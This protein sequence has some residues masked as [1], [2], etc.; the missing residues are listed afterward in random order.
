MQATPPTFT[1]AQIARA[2]GL[3]KR[4]VFQVLGSVTSVEIPSQGG[5]AHAWSVAALPAPFQEH[6][7][8]EAERCGF[9]SAEHLL[10]DPSKPWPPP[11]LRLSEISPEAWEKARKLKA[12]LLAS[13]RRRDDLGLTAAEFD[14]QGVR[15]YQ[16]AFGY[17]IHPRHFRRLLERTLKRDAGAEDFE[18]LDLYLPENP[19][20]K[21]DRAPANALLPGSVIRQLDAMITAFAAASGPT[22]EQRNFVWETVFELFEESGEGGQ[23]SASVKAAFETYLVRNASFLGPN[24]NAIRVNWSRKYQQWEK[25]GRQPASLDDRRRQGRTRKRQLTEDEVE[26]LRVFCAKRDNINLGWRDFL[27]SAHALPETKA[28]H[29]PSGECR[30]QVPRWIRKLVKC[31]TTNLQPYLRGPR[32]AKLQG[33]YIER[34]PNSQAA[35]DTDQ[36]DDKTLE[37]YW[38][39]DTPDGRWFGQGQLLVWIDER[40]WFIYSFALISDKSYSGFSIRNSWTKKAETWGL[41]RE[42]IYVEMG[43]WREAKVFAGSGDQVGLSETEMGVRR[44]GLKIK[45]ALLPRGK[46]I[47]RVFG[48][49]S[50]LLQGLPGYAGRNQ[51]VDKWETVQKQLALCRSGKEDPAQFFLSKQQMLDVLTETADKINN[52]AKWGKYHGG[53]TPTQVFEEKF[54]T[55]LVK[56]PDGCRHLFASNKIATTVG[57]NGVRFEF[58]RHTFTYKNSIELGRLKGERVICWFHPENPDFISVTDLNGENPIVVPREPLVPSHEAGEAF[59]RANEASANF[60]RYHKEMYRTLRP[61]FDAAFTARLFRPVVADAQTLE[62]HTNIHRQQQAAEQAQQQVRRDRTLAQRNLRDVGLYHD[63]QKPLRPGQADA[64]K[65]LKR[66]LAEP[67][68]GGE[69]LQTNGDRYE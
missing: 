16:R 10:A 43:I 30:P 31:S 15:D 11:D 2:L 8:A 33:A 46:I 49:L 34:D 18:R 32:A 45:H 6:L 41:P 22:N 53:K 37:I 20:R 26:W 39:E 54:T 58:G 62:V 50:D 42:R 23:I 25:A 56:I 29:S 36:S 12:A 19:A 1:A 40:S 4:R 27:E 52:T 5:P 66:L 35:G 63:P 14:A 68:D 57:R 64:A 13:L 21:P 3:S 17:G 67:V 59:V 38:W 48:S 44:L 24:L 28:A 69:Q 65:E 9:R 51:A 60:D 7:A 61:K 55:P 47:E